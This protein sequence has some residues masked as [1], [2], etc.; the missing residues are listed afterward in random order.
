MP[1]L[2]SPPLEIL[3]GVIKLRPQGAHYNGNN[4]SQYEEHDYK[5]DHTQD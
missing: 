2:R 5:V 1:A 4:G 3:R